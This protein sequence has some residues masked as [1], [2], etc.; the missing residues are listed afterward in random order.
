MNPRLKAQIVKELLSYLRDP[1]TRLVLVGPPLL[2]LFLFSFAATLEVR[3]IDVAVFDEDAGRASYELLAR[4][5]ASSFVSELVPVH[6][7]GGLRDLLNQRKALVAIHIPADF[8]RNLAAG[9]PAHA[10]LLVDGRRANSGQIAAGYLSSVIAAFEAAPTGET[11]SAASPIAVRHWFNPN[12]I[13]RWFI[14]PGLAAILAML[15]S[16]LVTGLSIAREREMGTFDQLLVSPASPI[17]IVIGKMVPALI[18]GTLL[19]LLMV[20]AG[21]FAFR[22][23]FSGSFGLLLLALLVFILSVV[24]VGLMISSVC[25]TQQQAILGIFAVAVPV[26][27]ISGFATPVENMPYVLQLL[28]EASPLKHF[29]IIVQ[30]TFLK[31]L[32]ASDVFANLWPMLVIAAVTLSTAVVIVKGRLQ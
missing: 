2:Q 5:E 28:A 31:A 11:G 12:L 10:Q 19:G 17:E 3:N 14:V 26:I 21:V 15:T 25:R 4:I 16:L 8:S 6:S 20:G 27:L 7:T 32:P 13:Y 30:G 23:P 9:R 22:I 18:L 29:L 1:R 24:G